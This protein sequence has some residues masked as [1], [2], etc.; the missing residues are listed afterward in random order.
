MAVGAG[1][2]TPSA[3]P[4]SPPGASSTP[5]GTGNVGPLRC[6]PARQRARRP[7]MRLHGGR[8][9]RRP[10]TMRWLAGTPG[11]AHGGR[12]TSGQACLPE[13]CQRF[14]E[15]LKRQRLAQVRI[16]PGGQRALDVLGTREPTDGDGRPAARLRQIAQF[17]DECRPST[18]GIA[19]SEITRR[20]L[21][22]GRAPMHRL[23]TQRPTRAHLRTSRLLRASPRR[24]RRAGCGGRSAGRP[25]CDAARRPPGHPLEQREAHP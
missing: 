16:E 23:P 22:F 19:M 15:L 5:A 13:P 21:R 14:G 11:G 10:R 24:R 25:A 12:D 4:G 6:N 7:D 18:S 2:G 17:R 9:Q 8:P 1:T 3:N 20:S